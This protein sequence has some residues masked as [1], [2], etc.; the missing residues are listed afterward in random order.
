MAC[1]AVANPAYNQVVGGYDACPSISFEMMMVMVEDGTLVHYVSDQHCLCRP[2]PD[3]C[4]AAPVQAITGPGSP[5]MKE[6]FAGQVVQAKYWKRI[7][8]LFRVSTTG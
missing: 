5:M 1:A 6:R 8:E 7:L 2:L 3:V 4:A